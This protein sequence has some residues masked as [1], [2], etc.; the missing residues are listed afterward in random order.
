MVDCIARPCSTINP[1][2]Y[3]G[4]RGKLVCR[5]LRSVLHISNLIYHDCCSIALIGRLYQ[6][7]YLEPWRPG[8]FPLEVVHASGIF[9]Q[10]IE[11]A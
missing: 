6:M 5:Q 9:N 1:A 8:K 11:I 4:S 3:T 7:A 2:V 10:A